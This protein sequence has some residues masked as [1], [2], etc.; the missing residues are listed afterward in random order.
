MEGGGA[1]GNPE[2]FLEEAALRWPWRARGKFPDG[3]KGSEGS[4][5]I[6]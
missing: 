4:H 6:F 2:G 3:A 5:H 1:L